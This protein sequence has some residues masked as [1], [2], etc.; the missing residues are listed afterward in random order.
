MGRG[1]TIESVEPVKPDLKI[2]ETNEIGVIYTTKLAFHYFN[3]QPETA[4]RERCLIMT[5]SLAGFMDL[6]GNPQYNMSKFSLRGLLRCL[7]RTSWKKSIRVNIIAPWYVW[8]FHLCRMR[9][10]G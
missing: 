4:E 8:P 6:P 2:L 5:A 3:Q 1:G 10:A 7:R 9:T